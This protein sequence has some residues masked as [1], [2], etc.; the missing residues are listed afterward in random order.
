MTPKLDIVCDVCFYA[1]FQINL[2][3][4]SYIKMKYGIHFPFVGRNYA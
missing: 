4:S 2:Y 3:I 1:L